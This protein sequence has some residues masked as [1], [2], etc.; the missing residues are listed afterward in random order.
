MATAPTPERLGDL[1][2]VSGSR[3]VGRYDLSPLARGTQEITEAGARLGQTIAEVGQSAERLG[4]LQRLTEATDANA[5]I[6]QRLIDLRQ[7]YGDDPD[8]TTLGQRWRNEAGQIVDEG[9]AGIS[10]AGLRAQVLADLRAPLAQ[11]HAAVQ[12]QAFR[13][14]AAAHA[15][16]RQAYLQDLIA[17]SSL[18][19]DDAVMAG[20]I[21]AYHAMIDNAVDRGFQ[22]PE[23]AAAEKRSAALALCAGDYAAMARRDPARAVRELSFAENEAGQGGDDREIAGGHPLLGALPEDQRKALLLAGQEREDA[24]RIDA[25]RAPVLAEQQRQRTSDEAERAIIG[26]LAN[27]GSSVTANAVLDNAAL[28]PEAKQRLAAA[29]A[30]ST[31]PA[32]PADASATEAQEILANVRR[33]ERDDREIAAT[34][35][36]IDAYN[37]GG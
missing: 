31:Q 27:D 10:D 7:R 1:P 4:R 3:A 26:D 5:F 28:T 19:P 14:A 12:D 33:P 34:A 25:E 17:H 11:E 2:R 29:L 8:Y 35:P 13:G 24:N 20:G 23:G 32:P 9:L 6:H 36:L 18:N 37:E 30:R 22:S 16:A 21:N 15:D